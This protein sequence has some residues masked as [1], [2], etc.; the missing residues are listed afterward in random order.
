MFVEKGGG[1]K[2]E[3]GREGCGTEARIKISKAMRGHTLQDPVDH[4]K[5]FSFTLSEMGNQ[6]PQDCWKKSD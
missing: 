3:G 5:D 1:E 2:G 6:P 4:Y